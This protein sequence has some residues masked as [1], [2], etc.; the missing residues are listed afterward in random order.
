MLNCLC[1]LLA[2]HGGCTWGL[3]EIR[4]GYM[5]STVGMYERGPAIVKSVMDFQAEG[6]LKDYEIRLVCIWYSQSK[7]YIT[8]DN[9]FFN[10][11]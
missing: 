5:D 4:L 8:V 6:N 3:E 11:Y 9:L 2:L 7:A 10:R 1:I